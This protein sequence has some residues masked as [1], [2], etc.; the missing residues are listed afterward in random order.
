MALRNQLDSFFQRYILPTLKTGEGLQ[1][2]I[3]ETEAAIQAAEEGKSEMQEAAGQLE[4]HLALFTEQHYLRQLTGEGPQ[5]EAAVAAQAKHLY[6]LQWNF[7]AFTKSLEM[8]SKIIEKCQLVE[9][10]GE[11]MQE[12]IEVLPMKEVGP[13]EIG[14][15]ETDFKK[16]VASGD[17]ID[18]AERDLA[19]VYEE[20]VE[21]VKQGREIRA[22][23]LEGKDV[24]E[25]QTEWDK[26]GMTNE[27]VIEITQKN[28]ERL[29][30]KH[31]NMRKEATRGL[32][33]Y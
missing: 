15:G 8:R 17:R 18:T 25:I 14:L 5:S 28:V 1:H 13:D 26:S 20:I 7:K 22:Y 11:R 16:L 32:E 30:Q 23:F 24:E 9:Y 19:A 21:M 27:K 29:R 10:L 31:V 12:L 4:S 6:M 2:L 3:D 33:H